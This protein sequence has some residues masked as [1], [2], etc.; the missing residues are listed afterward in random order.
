MLATLQDP[1]PDGQAVLTLNFMVGIGHP[2]FGGDPFSSMQR[3]GWC[4]LVVCT[5]QGIKEHPIQDVLST[6]VGTCKYTVY[7]DFF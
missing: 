7:Q 4:S 3:A 2:P 6:E 5:R 1:V